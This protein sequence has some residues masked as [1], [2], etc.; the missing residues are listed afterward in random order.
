MAFTVSQTVNLVNV[1]KM[2]AYTIFAIRL[3]EVANVFQMLKAK[4]A[5]SVNPI[6][7]IFHLVNL[8]IVM[9]MEARITNVIR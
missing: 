8:A 2:E 3:M 6:I 9:E 5:I 1:M 7:S 4:F